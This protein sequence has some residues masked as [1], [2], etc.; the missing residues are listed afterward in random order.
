MDGADQPQ[1]IG[2]KSQTTKKNRGHRRGVKATPTTSK[3]SARTIRA[4]QRQQHVLQLRL[5]GL[6][7]PKIATT[8]NVSKS[9]VERDLIA[10]MQDIIREPAEQV[11]KMEMQRL[12]AM[13]TAHF[14]PACQGNIPSTHALLR[15]ME[16]RAQLMGWNKPDHHMAAKLTINDGENRHLQIEFVLPGSHGV[17][18]KQLDDMSSPVPPRSPSSP[19]PIGHDHRHG[20][21]GSTPVRIEP[22]PDDLV[23]E[24]ADR[25]PS[26]FAKRRGSWME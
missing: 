25:Q 9:Q 18:R 19:Q 5:A 14:V 12:D 4:R 1:P 15:I 13:T 11:F 24:R 20:G 22:S 21:Q 8:V 17:G 6:S 16:H 26:A 23:L 7:Y 10:A 3:R 2:Q